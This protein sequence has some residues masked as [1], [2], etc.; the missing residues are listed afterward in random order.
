MLIPKTQRAQELPVGPQAF[1]CAQVIS[2][3][4]Y[5]TSS[6]RRDRTDQSEDCGNQSLQLSINQLLFQNE[7]HIQRRLRVLCT[8]KEKSRS[9]L[10]GMHDLTMAR[11]LPQ[12]E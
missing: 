10:Q 6:S 8:I 3:A 5:M 4:M 9:S 7:N 11:F 1:H 2:T 12:W